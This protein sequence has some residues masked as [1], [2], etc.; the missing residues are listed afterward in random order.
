M[1]AKSLTDKGMSDDYIDPRTSPSYVGR[2]GEDETDAMAH[3]TTCGCGKQYEAVSE[4]LRWCPA[5]RAESRAV[6]ENAER[7]RQLAEMKEPKPWE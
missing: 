7:M 2:G 5:C 6:R 3:L 4:S 1:T